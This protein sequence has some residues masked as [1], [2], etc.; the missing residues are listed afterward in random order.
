[1]RALAPSGAEAT[2]LRANRV[3]GGEPGPAL[4]PRSGGHRLWRRAPRRSDGA[5]ADS[6]Q[7]QGATFWNSGVPNNGTAGPWEAASGPACLASAAPRVSDRDLLSAPRRPNSLDVITELPFR[8]RHLDVH[9]LESGGTCPVRLGQTSSEQG[10]VTRS[11][12]VLGGAVVAGDPR[13][14][15]CRGVF[16]TREEPRETPGATRRHAWTAV[17]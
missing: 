13:T 3:P 6:R 15:L 10:L 8:R 9:R 1:M 16:R 11:A 12:T 5:D 4:Q 2:G 7:G 17:S 14:A